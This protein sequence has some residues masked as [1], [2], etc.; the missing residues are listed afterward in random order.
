MVDG[1]IERPIAGRRRRKPWYCRIADDPLPSARV[2]TV[3]GALQVLA[4][5][6]RAADA[7][8]GGRTRI[9]T[10]GMNRCGNERVTD[11]GPSVAYKPVRIFVSTA[12]SSSPYT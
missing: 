9:T 12:T 11:V 8:K 2:Q 3:S 10:I 4:L 7:D 5:G 6:S 1:W